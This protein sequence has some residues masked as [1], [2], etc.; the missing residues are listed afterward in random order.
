M[1]EAR[2]ALLRGRAAGPQRPKDAIQ[3]THHPPIR[4]LNHV[5][6]ANLDAASAGMSVGNIG[7]CRLLV[8]CARALRRR[9]YYKTILRKGLAASRVG[10]LTGRAS[11]ACRR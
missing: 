7:G 6:L 2:F 1:C 10:H 3:D 11:T 5:A 9:G 4:G 8:T